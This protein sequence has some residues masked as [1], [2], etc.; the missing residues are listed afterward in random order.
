M[1][2][3]LAAPLAQ[4]DPERLLAAVPEDA[5]LVATLSGLDGTRQRASGNAWLELF[6]DDEFRP[7]VE[8][9][10]ELFEEALDDSMEEEDGALRRIA[11]PRAWFGAVHGAAAAFFVPDGAE[12]GGAGFFVEPGAD[13]AAFDELWDSLRDALRAESSES[14]HE[15]QG[16]E[17]A[18][19]QEGEGEEQDVL[20]LF[21]VASV[22]AL[23]LG[24]ERAFVLELAQGGIDRLL[25]RDPSPGF[26][27][28]SE[29]AEARASVGGT[30]AF[31]LFADVGGLVRLALAHGA[32]EDAED[33]EPGAAARREQ[34][35]ARFGPSAM[36]HAYV[37]GDI[38]EDERFD[39]SL[40]IHLPPGSLM[41]S[42][43]T[44]FSTAPR[45]L[46]ALAP[47]DSVSVW[48]GSFDL[49]GLWR[50]VRSSVEELE[51]A[52][53]EQLDAGVA[54]MEAMLGLRLEQDL[55]Q[56]VRGEYAGINVRLPQGEATPALRA[57]LGED[58]GTFL[59]AAGATILRVEDGSEVEGMLARVLS[60]FGIAGMVEEEEFQGHSVQFIGEDGQGL[61]WCCTDDFVVLSEAPTP[62]R[63]VLARV[64]GKDLPSILSDSRYGAVLEQNPGAAFV[65]MGDARVMIET[66]LEFT[67]PALRLLVAA[68]PDFEGADFVNELLPLLPPPTVARRYLDGVLY[69]TAVVKAE[70]LVLRVAGR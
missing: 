17:L 27:H 66:A 42:A 59:Q 40:S 20:I 15:Y 60:A 34:L 56:Q 51:P 10:G 18:L 64:G 49:L 21:D 70:S 2:L 1:V 43:S 54:G 5:L 36:R 32:E 69:E 39:L 33:A 24:G 26:A 4:G 38:G 7:L 67:G 23:V 53:L 57:V 16:V 29:L 28:D 13:A 31:E 48:I 52:A 35:L 55:L 68:D 6:R 45:D 8:R 19:F 3:W 11:D 63:T 41:Q 22:R 58:A 62:L 30:R 65:A 47:A 50:L 9:L 61:H 46:L 14:A 44:L 37:A 12:P 25:G